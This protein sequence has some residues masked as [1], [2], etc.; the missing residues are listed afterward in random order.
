MAAERKGEQ[1]ARMLKFRWRLCFR[2][3]H[4]HAHDVEIVD[5]H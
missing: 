2:F 5:Y 1:D 4:G 3:E